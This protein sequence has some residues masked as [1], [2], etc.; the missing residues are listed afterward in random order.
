M[1]NPV[2]GCP[3]T[4]HSHFVEH[5]H[6]CLHGRFVILTVESDTE[7]F[8]YVAILLRVSNL[9]KLPYRVHLFPPAELPPEKAAI[10]ESTSETE[11]KR[12]TVKC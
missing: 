7:N 10:R 11:W 4:N 6:D 2:V 1:T 3:R 9:R 5:L 8:P 12:E